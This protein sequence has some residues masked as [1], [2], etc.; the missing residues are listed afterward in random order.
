[1]LTRIRPRGEPAWRHLQLHRF[2]F[3]E[4]PAVAFETRRAVDG[5]RDSALAAVKVAHAEPLFEP[6][7]ALA[8]R[9]RTPTP[10]ASGPRRRSCGFLLP[11][12]T[13]EIRS[14]FPSPPP[15]LLPML[16]EIADIHVRRLRNSMLVFLLPPGSYDG[17]TS[18]F[19]LF[20]MEPSC[21][22]RQM[23]CPLP[24]DNPRR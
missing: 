22:P 15:M 3:G 8:D 10:P 17:C 24:L 23:H 16:L 14:D 20:S 11:A 2:D 12:R 9:A 1:M 4:D 19:P 18:P 13:P 21:S 7:N 5:E 6:R